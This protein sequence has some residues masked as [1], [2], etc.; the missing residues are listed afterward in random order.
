MCQMDSR[1]EYFVHCAGGYRSM[2]FASILKTRGFKKLVDVA[3]GY[4]AIKTVIEN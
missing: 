2:A 1:E 3:G 4:A